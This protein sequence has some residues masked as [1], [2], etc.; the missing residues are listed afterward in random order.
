MNSNVGMVVVKKGQTT[1]N[2]A[3]FSHLAYATVLGEYNSDDNNHITSYKN[4]LISI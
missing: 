3:Y 1:V 4:D 2:M